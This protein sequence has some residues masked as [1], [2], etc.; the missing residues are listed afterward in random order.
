LPIPGR[1]QRRTEVEDHLS[2]AVL[3]AISE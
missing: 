1:R 2:G 3:A